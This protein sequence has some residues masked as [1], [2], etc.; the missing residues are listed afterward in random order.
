MKTL[1]ILV[2]S[3]VIFGCSQT[4]ATEHDLTSPYK[5]VSIES[6]DNTYCLYY[7]R[8]GVSY[9]YTKNNLAVRDSIGKFNIN[10]TVYVTLVKK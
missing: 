9:I 5:V 2:L 4:I 1:I 10:D 6:Y 3:L 8:T 7:V